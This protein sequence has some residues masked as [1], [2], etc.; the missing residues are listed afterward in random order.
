MSFEEDSLGFHLIENNYLI[1]FGKHSSQLYSLRK[2][3]PYLDFASVKQVH[4]DVTI[5]CTN[6]SLDFATADGIH[7]NL[8]KVA[9]LVKTADCIPILGFHK[10][11]EHL[12]SIHAGW[13]GV[14]NQIAK[15]SILQLSSQF[16]VKDW[17]IFIGPHIQKNSFLVQS[18]CLEALAASSNQNIDVWA[19]KKGDGWLIDLNSLILDQLQTV[20]IGSEQITWLNYDTKSDL[21]FHS[22]RRDRD[23]SGR[24][25]NFIARL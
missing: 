18:D 9:L 13:R 8:S 14:V 22:F 17:R 19:E 15:K 1:F 20:G 4:G 24:Q 23:L 3:F 7:S 11:K 6:A 16:S 10:N 2:K 5:N 21:R 25:F 12:L